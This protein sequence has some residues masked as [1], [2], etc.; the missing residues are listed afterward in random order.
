MDVQAFV[1]RIEAAGFTLEADGTDLVVRPF[2]KLSESQK[3]FIRRHKPELL[4]VLTNRHRDEDNP[5]DPERCEI[6]EFTRWRLPSGRCVAFKLAIPK[7]KYDGFALLHLLEI[8][9]R[10]HSSTSN[11]EV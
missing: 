10:Q 11:D 3:G 4:A 9:G 2:S 8:Q 5:A 1:P 7:E 6:I